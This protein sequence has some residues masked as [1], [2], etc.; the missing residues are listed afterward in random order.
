MQNIAGLRQ[1]SVTCAQNIQRLLVFI[2]GA[3]KPQSFR[4]RYL[5]QSISA[6]GATAAHAGPVIGRGAGAGYMERERTIELVT[7]ESSRG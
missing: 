4:G 3:E 7:M 2:L 6:H 1:T 5:P